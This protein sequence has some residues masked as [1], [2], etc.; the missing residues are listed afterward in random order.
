MS[1]NVKVRLQRAATSKN[2][3]CVC[4][5]L[6]LFKLTKQIIQPGISTKPDHNNIQTIKM[7][8][9]IVDTLQAILIKVS[10]FIS[11]Y[12]FKACSNTVRFVKNGVKLSKAYVIIT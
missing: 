5:L 2:T 7:H 11:C 6:N 10:I 3:V 9:I 4:L 8:H 1:T 12:I